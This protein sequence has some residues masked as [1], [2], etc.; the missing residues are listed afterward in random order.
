MADV[1]V[2]ITP[3]TSVS[4]VEVII[5]LIYGY[6]AMLILGIC[7]IGVYVLFIVNIITGLVL[8]KRVG[9]GF[10]AKWVEQATKIMAY[11]LFA[12]DER[13]PLLMEF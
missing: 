3:G 11:Y 8:A 6:I 2:S 4:R 13:P 10:L 7:A 5:R 9:A 12:T 1:N